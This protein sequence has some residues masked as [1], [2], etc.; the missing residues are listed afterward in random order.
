MAEER[1]IHVNLGNLQLPVWV[2]KDNE[3]DEELIRLSAKIINKRMQDYQI[4]FSD[5]E[6]FDILAMVTL[7]IA[8]ELVVEKHRKE[9]VLDEEAIS[10]ISRKLDQIL[11]E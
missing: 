10:R 9:V 5:K 3:S 4:H 11:E 7:E 6:K 2:E 8:R 1:I